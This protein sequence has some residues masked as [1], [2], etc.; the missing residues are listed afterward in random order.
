MTKNITDMNGEL[1]NIETKCLS[2][3]YD[4]RHLTE[5]CNGGCDTLGKNTRFDV[6]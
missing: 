3:D 5:E 4:A 6:L 1:N 2:S